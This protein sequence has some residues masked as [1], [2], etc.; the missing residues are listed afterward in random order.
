[1]KT[2]LTCLLLMLFFVPQGI[3]EA[4]DDAEKKAFFNGFLYQHDLVWDCAHREFEMFEWGNYVVFD[5]H[6]ACRHFDI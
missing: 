5:I 2:L 1:M 6:C 3:W 4:F